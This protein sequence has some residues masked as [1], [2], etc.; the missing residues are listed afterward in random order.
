MVSCVT[1]EWNIFEINLLATEN[2]RIAVNTR[3]SWITSTALNDTTFCENVGLLTSNQTDAEVG[4]TLTFTSSSTYKMVLAAQW[5]I[6]TG[7]RIVDSVVAVK[8][9]RPSSGYHNFAVS[10]NYYDYTNNTA[11]S[12]SLY[13]DYGVIGLP[14][15]YTP[16]G[17]PTKLIILC[18]GSGDRISANTNPLSF[19]GWEYYLAK[20]YAVMDMNGVSQAWAT[21]AGFPMTDR[22]YCNKYL[23]DSYQKGYE[24]VLDK[25]NVDKGKVFIA[26]ISMGGGASAL[27]VQSG[28]FPVVAHCAFCPALSVYK[29][30]YLS[31]WGG[32]SQ[33]KTIAGQWG[34]PDW[35]TTTPS[36]AY[37]L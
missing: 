16:T 35:S 23:I 33:Q 1:G 2:L 7:D 37:F 22:H 4:D 36:Q 12:E 30:D 24:Y 3:C 14:T 28:I 27:L 29:Q 34:F 20:G 17:T 11:D 15:N 19:Q 8:N 26:G 32:E 6:E 18:G 21:A 10:V 13:T 25:F 9:E 5:E 31:S